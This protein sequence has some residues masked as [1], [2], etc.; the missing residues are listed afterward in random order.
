MQTIEVH[1]TVADL[2]GEWDELSGGVAFAGHRWLR[3]VEAVRPDLQPRY[4]VVRRGGRM[5]SR[6]NF[7]SGGTAAGA[8][9]AAAQ[10]SATCPSHTHG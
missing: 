8:R 5:I 4:L 7:P 1:H 10:K 2:A 9:C 6:K 3:L